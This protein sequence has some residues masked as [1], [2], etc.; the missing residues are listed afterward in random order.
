MFVILEG[1]ATRG[2]LT[3]ILTLVWVKPCCYLVGNQTLSARRWVQAITVFYGDG[4]VKM[5][6]FLILQKSDTM[7]G[8]LAW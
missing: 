4:L 1:N 3:I 5:Y 8:S 7:R 6:P 2:F